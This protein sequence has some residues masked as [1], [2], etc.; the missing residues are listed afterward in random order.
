M[1]ITLS[2]AAI[3]IILNMV[4]INLFGLIGAS[5]SLLFTF[6]FILIFKYYV[7]LKADQNVDKINLKAYRPKNM[8]MSVK[9]IEKI[10]KKPMPSIQEGIKYLVN[11]LK[12]CNEF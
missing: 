11:D 9:R 1:F 8:T 6:T 12:N 3:N 10:I 5:L 4:L 2:G 7:N